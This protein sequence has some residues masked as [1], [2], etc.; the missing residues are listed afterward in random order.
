MSKLNPFAHSKH[1]VAEQF[2]QGN[3]HCG[4]HMSLLILLVLF[5]TILYPYKHSKQLP[6]KHLTQFSGHLTHLKSI[7]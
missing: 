7:I 1:E 5:L 6:L 3:T 4:V 2:L